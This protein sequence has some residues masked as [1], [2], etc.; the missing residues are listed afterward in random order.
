MQYPASWTRQDPINGDGLA[1][2]GPEPGFE[3]LAY[4][5]LPVLGPSAQEDVFERLDYQVRQHTDDAARVVEDDIQQNVVRILSDGGTSE[6]AGRRFVT[7]ADG[8]EDF[9]ATTTV[10]LVTTTEDR[11][12]EMMCRVPTEL[13]PR[14][15]GACN[16]LLSGLTLTR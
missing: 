1:A 16:Q 10:A 14:W 7:Q 11:D 13:Y 12:V 4:G 6:V 15:E 3:L 8:S 5:S 9:P 2:V